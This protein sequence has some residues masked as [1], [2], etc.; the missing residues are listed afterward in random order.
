MDE[1]ETTIKERQL[2]AHMIGV[3]S[4]LNKKQWFY[5]NYG[6]FSETSEPINTLVSKGLARFTG[7]QAN[8]SYFAITELGLRQLDLS[9]RDF[10]RGMKKLFGVKS[11]K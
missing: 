8:L 6:A 9:S 11:K 3:D 1:I 10:S 2:I 7:A 5:R 4:S